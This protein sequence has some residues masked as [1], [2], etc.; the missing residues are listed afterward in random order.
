MFIPTN[1]LVAAA[2]VVAI[3][4]VAIVGFSTASDR[5]FAKWRPIPALAMAPK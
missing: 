2:A 1:R 3:G 5:D 4:A